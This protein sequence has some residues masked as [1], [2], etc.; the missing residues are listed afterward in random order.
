MKNSG[1]FCVGQV[2]RTSHVATRPKKH[3]SDACVPR[4]RGL[5]QQPPPPVCSWL[6]VAGFLHV[7]RTRYGHSYLLLD[8]A[9]FFCFS[10]FCF[11]V[12]VFFGLLKKNTRGSCCCTF[13]I[14]LFFAFLS[15]PKYMRQSRMVVVLYRYQGRG[16]AYYS[17]YNTIKLM[18]VLCIHTSF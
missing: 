12:F 4:C 7:I 14:S 1:S 15:P 17:V 9:V 16:A 2:P 18:V 13:T 11:F 3:V 6:V 10:L 8:H 5:L